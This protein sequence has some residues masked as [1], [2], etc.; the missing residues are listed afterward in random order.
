[1]WICANFI[2]LVGF[3]FTFNLMNVSP[4]QSELLDWYVFWA[5]YDQKQ[6]QPLF[7]LMSSSHQIWS[8]VTHMIGPQEIPVNPPE[9][10][11]ERNGRRTDYQTVI[12]YVKHDIWENLQQSRTAFCS[13]SDVYIFELAA[14]QI[15]VNAGSGTEQVDLVPNPDFSFYSANGKQKYQ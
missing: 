10:A 1:M 12:P 8:S 11:M 14:A 15:T 7:L 6:Y 3:F 2:L 13:T 9:I 4:V 5:S